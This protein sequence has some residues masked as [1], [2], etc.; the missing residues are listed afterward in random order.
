VS[1][2][3]DG[4]DSDSCNIGQPTASCGISLLPFS[5]FSEEHTS[6][7]DS[8]RCRRRPR[9][10]GHML[11][12]LAGTVVGFRKY[13]REAGSVQ[14]LLVS[15][16]TATVQ[17]ATTLSARAAEPAGGAQSG[18]AWA[19]QHHPEQLVSQTEEV[20][21]GRVAVSLHNLAAVGSAEGAWPHAL[22]CELVMAR[23]WPATTLRV[24]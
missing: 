22:C 5:P 18:G 2:A 16:A 6:T 12:R 21:L 9:P 3:D 4:R 24:W 13:L 8:T 14:L 17:A 1:V 11:Y 7:A 10:A 19:P 15:P 20:A 23:R